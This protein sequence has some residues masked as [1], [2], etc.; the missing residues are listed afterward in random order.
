MSPQYASVAELH[1]LQMLEI[2]PIHAAATNC[3]KCL[4]TSLTIP[5]LKENGWA[6]NRFID[7]N[8]WAAGAGVSARGKLSLDQRL[9]TRP[10]VQNTIVNLL[11]L[12]QMFVE[13]CQEQVNEIEATP[14]EPVKTEDGTVLG[15]TENPN[16]DDAYEIPPVLELSSEEIEA[17]KDVEVTLDQI[18]RLT[19]AIRKAG[20]NSRLKRADRSFSLE[21]PK[22]QELKGFLELIAHPRGLKA[23][24]QLTLVQ[25]RLIEA[26]LRRWHR[27][28]YAKKHA[29][30]LARSDTAPVEKKPEVIV[31]VPEEN[32]TKSDSKPAVSFDIPEE[33]EEVIGVVQED[34]AP[35]A[36]SII[37]PT[38]TTAASAIEGNIIV[39]D[40]PVIR[41]PA[42]V[43]SRVSSR[44]NYPRPPHTSQYHTVFK[45]PCCLQSLPIAY[46]ERSQWKYFSTPLLV[47]GVYANLTLN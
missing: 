22:V 10:E 38:A 36:V 47:I 40:K 37:A 23:E 3:R 30:K 5:R 11:E 1:H 14:S 31:S 12:L 42:T 9:S 6:E 33:E 24:G 34:E 35:R 46:T 7:F 20:A 16:N 17:R 2:Q 4:A 32:T 41:T 15:G 21:S 18:I 19:V 39:P 26:N 43:I 45:C 27:F 8:L 44:I 29:K 28:S 25:S 13:N